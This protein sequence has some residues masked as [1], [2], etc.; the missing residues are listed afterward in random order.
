MTPPLIGIQMREDIVNWR[1]DLHA[2]PE[3][4][5]DVHH[6]AGFA[7]PK[8]QEFGCDEVVTG[9]GKSGVVGAI[10][11]ESTTTGRVIGLR[12][13]MDALPIEEVTG[14][15]ASTDTGKMHACGHNCRGLYGRPAVAIASRTS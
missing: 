5:Y 14:S 4:L 12:P 8:L 3:L 10:S 13:D 7:A 15:P 9:I 11:G 6:P 1:R 2:H